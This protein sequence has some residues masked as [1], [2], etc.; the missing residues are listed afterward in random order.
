MI[1]ITE[2]KAKKVKLKTKKRSPPFLVFNHKNTT[3]GNSFVSLQV[4]T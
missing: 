1:I 4:D 2:I 3:V